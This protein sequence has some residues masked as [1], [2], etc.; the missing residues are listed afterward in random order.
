[1]KKFYETYLPYPK[2]SALLTE[3]GWS[4]HLHILSKTKTINT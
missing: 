1:M 2:L 4:N 3:I